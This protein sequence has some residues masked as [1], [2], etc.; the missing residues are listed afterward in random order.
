[1]WSH[2]GS[3]SEDRCN[4]ALNPHSFWPLWT[5]ALARIILRC[6]WGN[7]PDSSFCKCWGL[8][9]T[10][11]THDRSHAFSVETISIPLHQEKKYMRG[12]NPVPLQQSVCPNLKLFGEVEVWAFVGFVSLYS[13]QRDLDFGCSWC[14]HESIAT[15]IFYPPCPKRNW[16]G[17]GICLARTS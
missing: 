11:Q 3:F 12:L 8:H 6:S 2:V 17:Q 14:I 13:L 4:Q 7:C 10:N 15:L 1:M 16:S 9:H 5:R